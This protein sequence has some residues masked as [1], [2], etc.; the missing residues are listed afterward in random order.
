MSESPN[1]ADPDTTKSSKAGRNLPAAI[2]VGL[3]L[4]ALIIA[5]LFI[6][7]T[8][9]AFVVMVALSIATFEITAAMRTAKISLPAIPVVIGGVIAMLVTYFESSNHT[10][11]VMAVTVIAVFLYRLPRGADG[12]VRDV[13][14]GIFT[15]GYL[16]I[17]GSLVMLLLAP[18]DGPWRMLAFIG[19]TVASDVGGYA[20]GV[21]FG[22]HPLAPTISPK[23][24]WEGLGGSVAASSLIGVLFVVYGLGGAW[25]IGLVLGVLAALAGTLGD[26][27]E[28]LIKRDLGIKDMGNILPG[29]G[30]IMDRLD[31]LLVVAPVA[32]VV[33]HFLI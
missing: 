30:G 17:M 31:S 26:L 2:A 29:H 15:L 3:S 11:V 5:S 23:K 24:S 21:F 10:I 6:E 16:F 7:K 27:S 33:M 25:W 8:V 18:E 4:I 1:Q 12:F 13:S 28:S 32:F 14:A 20:A 9:F 22:K 19:C